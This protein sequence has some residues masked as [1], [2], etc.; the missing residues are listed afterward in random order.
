MVVAPSK[1]T[2]KLQPF[3]LLSL[4]PLRA[5]PSSFSHS[6]A[7]APHA[8][9]LIFQFPRC[10]D[11]FLGG[12]DECERYEDMICFNLSLDYDGTLPLES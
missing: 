6:G 7:G 1:K 3:F 8:S 10:L 4:P 2:K 5:V 12:T 11:V 9:T